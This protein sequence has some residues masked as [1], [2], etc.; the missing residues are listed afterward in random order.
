MLHGIRGF[1]RFVFT[2][3]AFGVELTNKGGSTRKLVE[4]L[5]V[6]DQN[7]AQA[8]CVSLFYAQFLPR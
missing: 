1:H 8:T 6:R 4:P 2:S 3:N 7:P 5:V